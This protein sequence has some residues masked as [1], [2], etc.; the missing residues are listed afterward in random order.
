MDVCSY[1]GVDVWRYCGVDCGIVELWR[2]GF[3]V[4]GI[5]M[6]MELLI[7][8]CVCVLSC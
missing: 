7:C 4:V 2:C 3:V 5:D 1:D 8:V 6:C